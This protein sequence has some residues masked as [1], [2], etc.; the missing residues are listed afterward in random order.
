MPSQRHAGNRKKE[1]EKNQDTIHTK[2]VCPP[3]EK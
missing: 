2:S 3:K 1:Q